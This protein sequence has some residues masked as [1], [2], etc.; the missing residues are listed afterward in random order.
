MCT[1]L[2]KN[3]KPAGGDGSDYHYTRVY[4]NSKKGFELVI[5]WD[6]K[7][8]G[9]DGEHKLKLNAYT[10]K[11]N[12]DIERESGVYFRDCLETEGQ[13]MEKAIKVMQ[14]VNDGEFD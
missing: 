2:P 10:R 5:Y 1:D 7:D 4:D 9:G 14:R 8:F 3:W 13:A 6:S 11:E 12:G